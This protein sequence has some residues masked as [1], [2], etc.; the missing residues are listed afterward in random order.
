MLPWALPL[1]RA[2]AEY[3]SVLSRARMPPLFY[4][5][6]DCV[7]FNQAPNRTRTHSLAHS[8]THSLTCSLTRSLTRECRFES[9]AW[10]VGR[11]HTAQAEGHSPLS[12]L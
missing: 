7:H 10:P 11:R 2:C 3:S 5:F 9:V 12:R 1:V 4:R 8:L 6:V